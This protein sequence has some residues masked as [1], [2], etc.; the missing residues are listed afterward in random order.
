MPSKVDE[1]PAKVQGTPGRF[2]GNPVSRNQPFK[3]PLTNTV[4]LKELRWKYLSNPVLS[5]TQY[6]IPWPDSKMG[7]KGLGNH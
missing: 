1:C 6:F 2:H 5:L 7:G 3:R 4:A